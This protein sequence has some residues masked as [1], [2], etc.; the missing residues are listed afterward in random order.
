MPYQGEAI[1]VGVGGYA[2]ASSPPPNCGRRVEKN[3]WPSGISRARNR[4]SDCD[5]W[6]KNF[7]LKVELLSVLDGSVDASAAVTGHDDHE[8]G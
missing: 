7:V 8:T 4:G 1:I 6:Y 5:P 3:A 2:D